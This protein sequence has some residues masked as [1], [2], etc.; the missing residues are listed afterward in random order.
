VVEETPVTKPI[1][2]K[3]RNRAIPIKRRRESSGE[4]APPITEPDVKTP[5]KLQKQS[6]GERL[7]QT[8]GD[9]AIP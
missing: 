7:R 6:T 1:K 8:T 2:K 3:Q 5:A 9:D 4:G